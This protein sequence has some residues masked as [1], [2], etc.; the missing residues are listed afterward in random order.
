MLIDLQQDAELAKINLRTPVVRRL[1]NQRSGIR[2]C[3]SY[4]IIK[5]PRSGLPHH[6]CRDKSMRR[7]CVAA[8][9]PH[10]AQC[11]VRLAS[12][13][14]DALPLPSEEGTT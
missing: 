8:N 12:M 1:T 4:F 9:L 3:A 13:R 6:C 14:V 2:I 5:A 10:T 7:P 11:S